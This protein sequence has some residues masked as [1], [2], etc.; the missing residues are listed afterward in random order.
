MPFHSIFSDKRGF[1]L[2]AF[3]RVCILLDEFREGVVA[4]VDEV[5]GAANDFFAA[6]AKEGASACIPMDDATCL[7]EK[8]GAVGDGVKNSVYFHPA[9][10]CGIHE[11]NS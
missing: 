3:L 4:V 6:I 2:P 5:D 7:I 8:D 11:I 9:I 10:L 1:F